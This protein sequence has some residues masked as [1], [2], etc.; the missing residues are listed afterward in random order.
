MKA[1][2]Q[3]SLGRYGGLVLAAVL[4]A[5]CG[6]SRALNVQI[7]GTSTMNSGENEMRGNAV[8]L[9][10]YELSNETNFRSATREAF[11]QDDVAALGE[12]RLTS[13]Q[14]RLFPDENRVIE[15]EPGQ[16]T[17]FIGVAADLRY[18]YQDQWRQIYPVEELRS[19]GIMVS[20]MKDRLRVDV[21]N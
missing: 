1:M 17:R 6:G 10:I 21:T 7:V 11:W 2:K 15:L 13:Q 16:D 3:R 4:L 19:K 20:V 14:L 8:V 5:G 9:R 18:P 12:E